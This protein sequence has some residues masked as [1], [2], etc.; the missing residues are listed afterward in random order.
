VRHV[1]KLVISIDDPVKLADLSEVW[2]L[3]SSGVLSFH[4]SG[5]SPSASV[6]EYLR[7]LPAKELLLVTT[8]DHP[9]LTPDALEFF[10]SAVLNNDADVTV[11]VVTAA[12]FRKHYPES[13]RS[14]IQ[15]RD[16]SFCGANLFAFRSGSRAT[17]AAAFWDYAGQFRKRPWR[18]VRTFGLVNL[19]LCVLRRLDRKAALV[20]AGRVIGARLAVVSLPFAECAIDV[21]SPADL[22]LATRILSAHE[23]VAADHSLSL[24]K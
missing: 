1:G 24:L 18:L 4:T 8:A 19:L 7:V 10:C 11:G 16:E 23:T 22:A 12:L 21:D 20:R 5:H 3:V 2:D 14:F 15:L 13:K 6:H 9:L 17:A